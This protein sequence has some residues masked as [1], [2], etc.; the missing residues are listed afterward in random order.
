MFGGLGG[1]SFGLA[2]AVALKDSEDY[3]S[4]IG[5]EQAMI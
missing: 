2:S 4:S 1:A 3:W 5:V